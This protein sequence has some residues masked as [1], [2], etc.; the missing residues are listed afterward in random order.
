MNDMECIWATCQNVVREHVPIG[1]RQDHEFSVAYDE[2][3]WPFQFERTRL[4]LARR[5]AGCRVDTDII[6]DVARDGQHQPRLFLPN[7]LASENTDAVVVLVHP[8]VVSA[9]KTA[10]NL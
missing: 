1:K 8:F 3:L 6:V 5:K 7:Q 10:V 2:S 9:L 4:R